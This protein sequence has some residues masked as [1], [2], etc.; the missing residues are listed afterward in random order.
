MREL[1]IIIECDGASYTI[2]AFGFKGKGCDKA[3]K[4]YE[5]V[6]GATVE[7]KKKPEHYMA[8]PVKGKLGA[9]K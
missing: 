3:T 7:V 9:R 4:P 6:L 1:E 2:E 8:E 5:Q